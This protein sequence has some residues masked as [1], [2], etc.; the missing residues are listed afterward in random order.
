MKEIVIDS[1]EKWSL[2]DRR[3][4]AL[5]QFRYINVTLDD[6]LSPLETHVGAWTVM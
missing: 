5:R 4:D 1:M 2:Y 6:P 3:A